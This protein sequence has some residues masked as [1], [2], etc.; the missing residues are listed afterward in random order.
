MTRLAGNRH[1][2][3]KNAPAMRPRLVRIGTGAHTTRLSRQAGRHDLGG[4]AVVARGG[5]LSA[6]KAL[7]PAVHLGGLSHALGNPF[8]RHEC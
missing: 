4:R 6:G 8:S 7:R 1:R 2:C 3:P 5:L